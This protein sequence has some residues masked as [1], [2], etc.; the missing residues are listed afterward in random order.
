MWQGIIQRLNACIRTIGRIINPPLLYVPVTM[1]TAIPAIPPVKRTV[2]MPAPALSAVVMGRFAGVD[3][4]LLCW[5]AFGSLVLFPPVEDVTGLVFCLLINGNIATLKTF[6][7]LICSS[8]P[9]FPSHSFP[10]QRT[11][12]DWLPL[13]VHV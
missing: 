11:P 5:P 12:H 7:A 4:S 6:V 3:F 9:V 1:N 13:P 10:Y 2:K 8:M